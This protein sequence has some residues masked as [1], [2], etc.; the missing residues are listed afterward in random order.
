M[1][2]DMSITEC[3]DWIQDINDALQLL[4]KWWK[5]NEQKRSNHE[6]PHQKSSS[7]LSQRLHYE[8][9]QY[10]QDYQRSQKAIESNQKGLLHVKVVS[11]IK[12]K[13]NKPDQQ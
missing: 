6:G 4:H 11:N 2:K 5:E 10:I 13:R 7:V 8:R 1:P 9:R 12:Q 3:L